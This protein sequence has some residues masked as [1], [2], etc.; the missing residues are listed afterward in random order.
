MTSL[1]W[2]IISALNNALNTLR[3]YTLPHICANLMRF[4]IGAA[5]GRQL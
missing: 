5:Y 4:L 3:R 1:W 2:A